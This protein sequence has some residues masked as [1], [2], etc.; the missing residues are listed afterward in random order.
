MLSIQRWSLVVAAALTL[1][2]PLSAQLT[3]APDGDQAVAVMSTPVTAPA[4]SFTPTL[5]SAR[6]FVDYTEVTAVAPVF[7]EQSRESEDVALMI[8]GG[9]A[10]VVGSVIGGDAGTIMMVGG[11]VMGLVGLYRYLR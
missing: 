8:V 3:T 4:L 2:V 9:A 5:E 11:G 7:R 1:A 6:A 10:L